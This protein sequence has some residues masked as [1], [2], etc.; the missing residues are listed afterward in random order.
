MYSYLKKAKGI[1]KCVIKRQ[2]KYKY[3]ENCLE[4]TQL[5]NKIKC[6]EKNTI[7]IDSLKN[8]IKNS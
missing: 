5:A 4:A 7:N 3:Y 2:L 6:L 1:E 8:I